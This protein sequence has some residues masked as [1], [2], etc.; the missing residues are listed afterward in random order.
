MAKGCI[1]EFVA[2]A[3]APVFANQVAGE[4]LVFSFVA[5]VVYALSP[6]GRDE[7]PCVVVVA[8]VL[9][10]KG[11]PSVMGEALPAPSVFWLAIPVSFNRKLGKRGRCVSPITGEEGRAGECEK[12]EVSPPPRSS[13][14][15]PGPSS[16]SPRQS[17]NAESKS[18]LS[19]KSMHSS[20]SKLSFITFIF[21][22]FV[23]SNCALC[24]PADNLILFPRQYGIRLS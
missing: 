8:V 10:G 20:S 19:A 2:V 15:G 13:F 14:T 7:V 16:S 4:G 22:V 5:T 12:S 24:M 1:C 21:V 6:P 9:G 23:L 18:E 17:S 3:D 11:S